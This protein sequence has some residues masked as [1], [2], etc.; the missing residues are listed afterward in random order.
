MGPGHLLIALTLVGI[1]LNGRTVTFVVR[2]V[3][4]FYMD[5]YVHK[6]SCQEKCC[7]GTCWMSRRRQNKEWWDQ[8]IIGE[9]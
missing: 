3:I 6:S 1:I 4:D 2:I 7:M 9:V 8:T 5:V